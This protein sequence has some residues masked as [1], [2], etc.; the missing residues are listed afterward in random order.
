VAEF[1]KESSEKYFGKD[2]QDMAG[3][4][5]PDEVAL[6]LCDSCGGMIYVDSDGKKVG[7]PAPEKLQ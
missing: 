4:A 6:V 7:E 5:K 3:I 1:C 2:L